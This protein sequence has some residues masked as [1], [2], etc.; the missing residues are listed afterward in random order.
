[1][2]NKQT[3]PTCLTPAELNFLKLVTGTEAQS[4]L[5]ALNF[6]SNDSIFHSELDLD[7]ENRI[8]YL[9]V[10]EL[11]TAIKDFI[12]TKKQNEIAI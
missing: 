6:I 8:Y 11:K 4:Y 12:N 2:S 3:I 7:R 9:R 10:N 5:E 1:M